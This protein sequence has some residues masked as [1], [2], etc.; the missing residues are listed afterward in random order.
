MIHRILFCTVEW[1]RVAEQV[2]TEF[3]ASDLLVADCKMI[4][5]LKMAVLWVSPCSVVQVH[6]RF[7]ATCCFHYQ[8]DNLHTFRRENQKCHLTNGVIVC[9]LV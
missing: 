9:I 2:I 6:R 4:A 3:G 7:V 1:Q 5:D 8:G